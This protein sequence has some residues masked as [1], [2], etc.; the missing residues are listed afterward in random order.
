MSIGKNAFRWDDPLLLED[1]LTEEETMV[2]DSARSYCQDQLLPRIREANRHEVFDCAVMTEMGSLG[3]LGSTL[4]EIYGGAAVNYVCYGLIAREVE[5]VDSGY[6]SAMSVQSS[7]VMY[8]IYAY[9]TEEQRRKYL[10]KLA[11]GEWIGCFGLTEPDAG[12]DPGSMKTR[13]RKTD[14]GWLLSGSKIWITNSPVADVFVVWAKDDAG[15]IKGFI[16]EKGM[17]GLSAPK[18]EGKFSLRAS[19]TGEIVMESVFVPDEN[20]LPNVEGLKGPFGCLNRARY[21][22]AWGVLGAAEFCFHA[23]RQYTLDRKQFGR[24]LANTQLVQLKLANME[25]EIALG[26]HACLRLGRLFDEQKMA[27]EM[28]SMLKR[29]NCGKALDIARI[30]R[31]MHGGNGISDEFHVIRHAMNLE[32]VNTYEGTHDVHALILGRAITGLNAFGG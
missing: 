21:G 11:R 18:I 1:A 14:G 19:I 23:S 30:A 24:P 6:R 20:R 13:A 28:I 25:T 22:I 26:L 17:K 3:F 9:G 15:I 31:D 27:P 12:S 10:P 4:P 32:A 8:P 16:L 5:R 2:R 7:L 29:N